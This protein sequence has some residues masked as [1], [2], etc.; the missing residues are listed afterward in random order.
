M[1]RI[2]T[3]F[4]SVITL[5]LIFGTTSCVLAKEY[6]TKNDMKNILNALEKENITN[7]DI[8]AYAYQFNNFLTNYNETNNNIASMLNISFFVESGANNII[9]VI[10]NGTFSNTLPYIYIDFD[11]YSSNSLLYGFESWKKD[12][13]NNNIGFNYSTYNYYTLYTNKVSTRTRSEYDYLASIPTSIQPEQVTLSKCATFVKTFTVMGHTKKYG[14]KSYFLNNYVEIES[15]KPTP[16]PDPNP[17]PSGDTPSSGEKT[18]LTKIENKIDETNKNLEDIKNKIPTSGDI[19][20]GTIKA[21]EEYWG[22]SGD[23]NPDK[24]GEDIKDV[25]NNTMD[26]ISGELSKNEIFKTLE[27]AEQG[28]FDLFKKKQEEKMYDLKLKWNETK[29]QET[30]LLESGEINISKMCREIP[31]LARLQ[32]YIRLIF[33]FTV[34]TNLIKQIYNLILSTLGIDNPYL[35]EEG[36]ETTIIN[37]ETGEYKKYYKKRKKDL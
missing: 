26:N 16:E 14:Y 21:N 15:L 27:T 9:F 13:N 4:L 3:I 29:Y 37:E 6:V 19:A 24:T 20:T 32:G 25:I 11:K 8:S 23:L 17:Q 28:F 10:S 34:I 33:N 5:I 36:E 31:E 12:N 1:K 18:D 35:Y 30:T 2:K 22:N 7:D